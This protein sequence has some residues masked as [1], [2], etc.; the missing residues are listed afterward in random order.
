MSV[1]LNLLLS[2][3]YFYLLFEGELK[4][5]NQVCWDSRYNLQI[6]NQRIHK[7]IVNANIEN[8]TLTISIQCTLTE[9]INVLLTLQNPKIENE[10]F[11]WQICSEKWLI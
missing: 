7:I 4:K 2:S 8:N 10:I 3:L 6:E 9:K 5:Y 1:E 11:W